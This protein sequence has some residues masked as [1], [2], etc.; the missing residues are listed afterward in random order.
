[1]GVTLSEAG[2][3]L[4]SNRG[5]P[6]WSV[7]WLRGFLVVLVV[8][9]QPANAGDLREVGSI[10]GSGRS[11]GGPG[12]GSH[13]AKGTGFTWFISPRDYSSKV[14]EHPS[15]R[16]IPDLR[17]VT[18]LSPAAKSQPMEPA[19]Q[20]SMTQ[21]PKRWSPGEGCGPERGTPT[22]GA[23]SP[24]GASSSLPTALHMCSNS[25]R[26]VLKYLSEF[27]F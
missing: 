24:A 8:K 11:P 10:H 1:M 14:M 27:S 13:L 4:K 2:T 23:A 16:V 9:N 21:Q 18:V 19:V 15:A 5:V 26:Q 12:A 20:K 17:P 6:R 3:G 25:G 7:Q 22:L